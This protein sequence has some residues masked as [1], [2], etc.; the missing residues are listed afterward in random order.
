MIS[1]KNVKRREYYKSH[2]QKNK[3]KYIAKSK[4]RKVK[5][6]LF[7]QKLKEATPCSDCNRKY[8][9]YIM[10]YDHI[11]GK[12][13]GISILVNRGVGMQILLQEIKKCDLVCSNCHRERTYKRQ[14]KAAGLG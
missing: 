14:Y 12:T 9:Y 8:P 2:Y 5:L 6:R 4:R 10:D 7:I 1:E 13:N 11:N 3:K